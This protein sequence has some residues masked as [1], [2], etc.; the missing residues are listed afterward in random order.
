MTQ[1]KPNAPNRR[2]IIDLSW[3]KGESVNAGVDKNSYLGTEVSLTFPTV[4]TIT[5]QLVAIGK[6]AHIYKVDM[7]DL[8]VDMCLP[9]GSRHGSQNFQCVSDAV[10]YMMRSHGYFIINYIDD[11]IGVG[12]PDIAHASFEFLCNLLERLGL[13][14]SVKKLCPPAQQAVCLGVL[15]DTAKGTISIPAE[16]L[17][18]IT[19]NVKMRPSIPAGSVTLCVEMC[20]SCPCLP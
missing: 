1:E 7:N 17:T 18:Q 19:D 9:F 12:T 20:M 11:F 8:Y 13:T 3:P 5:N 2:V 15:V 14:I 10:S 4:D 16:K 6:S